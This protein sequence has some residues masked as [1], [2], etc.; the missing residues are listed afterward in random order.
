MRARAILY[1]GHSMKDFEIVC[2]RI[3]FLHEASIL[4]EGTATEIKHRFRGK[5]LGEVFIKIARNEIE[6]L[7][8]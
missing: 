7:S 8:I 5:D 6:A 4:A 3:V 2:D 1:T